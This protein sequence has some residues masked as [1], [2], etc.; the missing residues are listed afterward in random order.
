MNTSDNTN[1]ETYNEFCRNLIEGN[2]LYNIDSTNLWGEYLLV[3]NKSII[4]VCN[5]LTYSILLFG[6]KKEEGQYKPRDLCISFTPDYASR[7]PFLKIIGSCKFKLIPA[8]EDVKVNVGLVAIYGSVD[9]HKYTKKLNIRK[10]Q[11]KKYGKDGKPVIKKCS[12]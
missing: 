6:L 10:P 8:I 11:I 2:I 1:L 3:V 7:I 12:N 5:M 4:H 9:L